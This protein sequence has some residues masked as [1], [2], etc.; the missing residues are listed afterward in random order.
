[1]TSSGIYSFMERAGIIDAFSHN[2][3]I[4]AALIANDKVS[5]K[6]CSSRRVQRRMN[7][8]DFNRTGR[9]FAARGVFSP[10]LGRPASTSAPFRASRQQEEAMG[11]HYRA[12]PIPS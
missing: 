2:R 7:N 3:R 9:D 6:C 4:G 12:R 11:G 1:M 10:T 5:D 8:G